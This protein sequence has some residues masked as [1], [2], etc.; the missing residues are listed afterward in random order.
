MHVN[1]QIANLILHLQRLE[2]SLYF[3][4]KYLYL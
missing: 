2:Q 1:K 3:I 4:L